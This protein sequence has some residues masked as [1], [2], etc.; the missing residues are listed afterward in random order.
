MEVENRKCSTVTHLAL[1]L[2]G[3]TVQYINVCIMF[4][5]VVSNRLLLTIRQSTDCG[6]EILWGNLR[7]AADQ[8]QNHLKMIKSLLFSLLTSSSVTI[9]YSSMDDCAFTAARLDFNDMCTAE[10]GEV[11]LFVAALL[12]LHD[13][14]ARGG[15]EMFGVT[16]R[17]HC[18]G[19]KAALHNT[20]MKASSK[21]SLS[22]YY[23]HRYSGGGDG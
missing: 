11:Q 12:W 15:W 18:L 2:V 1:V 8:S 14:N 6:W 3:T 13:G 17:V 10:I 4:V 21:C 19:I 7:L 20:H 9:F 22:L 5:G 16:D 23:I